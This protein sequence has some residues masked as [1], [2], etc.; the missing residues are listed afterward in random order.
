MIR[1]FK[2]PALMLA[3]VAVALVS[4]DRASA[5]E[6]AHARPGSALFYPVYDAQA[7][8]TTVITVTNTNS[9]RVSC[10]NNNRNGDVFVHF[11]YFDNEEC[12]EEDKGELLT[13]GDT[14]TLVTDVHVSNPTVGWLWVEAWDP[15]FQEAIDFDYLIGS[16]IIVKAGQATDFLWSYTPYSFRGLRTTG[17]A[18][19]CGFY[20][21][22]ADGNNDADFD[23]TE[24]EQFPGT[25]YLDNF[26]AEDVDMSNRIYL[27]VPDGAGGDD[28]FELAMQ[29]WNNAEQRFS[30]TDAIGCW[31]GAI[32]LSDLTL[33]VTADNLGGDPQELVVDGDSVLTG[34]IQFQARDFDD[35]ETR[36][37][38][39]VFAH[40]MNSGD[41][42]AGHELHYEGAADNDVSIRRF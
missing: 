34:W 30:N 8:A 41:F 33:Q 29:I 27:M 11:T 18:S 22:D 5:A 3:I 4:T 6:P 9:S 17:D 16:A 38:L 23:G 7:N 28:V 39:G 35:R 14:L 2:A 40:R 31:I 42:M 12:R 37:M 13:P 15:E 26:F 20:F 32:P 25:L 19:A 21:T 24:Y 1:G 10:Q 36:G